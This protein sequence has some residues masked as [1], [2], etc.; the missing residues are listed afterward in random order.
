MKNGTQKPKHDQQLKEQLDNYFPYESYRKGQR[1]L[2]TNIA[3]STFNKEHMVVEAVNG[4]GKTCSV[5]AATL[6]I[7]KEQNKQILYCC[8]THKQMDR[9]VEELQSI[10]KKVK[11][12]G[13]SIR[14]RVQMCLNG[15]VAQ[16]AVTTRDA[17]EICREL[18]KAHRCT[19]YEN[20]RRKSTRYYAVMKQIQE[21][22]FSAP[23]LITLGK[24]DK[25]CPY[26]LVKEILPQMDVAALSYNY[27]FDP[28]IRIIRN[29]LPNSSFSLT[30]RCSSV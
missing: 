14:G 28:D 19:Y 27:L 16:H 7:V 3:I 2:I 8:R 11:V 17:M 30:V 26:E 29:N 10:N 5:L 12:N 23:E 24:R 15:L 6:P 18:K 21:R 4:F 25:L 9:V 20:I 13:I 22:P 1:D